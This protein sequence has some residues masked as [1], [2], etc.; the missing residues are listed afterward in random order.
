MSLKKL[1]ITAILA[2]VTALPTMALA[3]PAATAHDS[4]CILTEHRVTSV[5]PLRVTER[6]G[7]GSS[8]RLAGAQVF[9]QAEPGLTAEWLQLTIQRHVTQMSSSG[10]A[11]CP[12]DAKDVRVS[13]ASAGP[14]FAVNITGKN[15]GQA[16]EILRRAQ[17]LV[18]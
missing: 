15:A 17:L 11:G 6:N 8:Q 1:T 2:T 7:R 9:V 14:G 13:V 5:Q 3:E 18:R 4:H 12:L 10:M 16:K